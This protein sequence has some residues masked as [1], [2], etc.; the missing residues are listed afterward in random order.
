MVPRSLPCSQSIGE[1]Y[2]HNSRWLHPQVSN[3]SPKS[4]KYCNW[5]L[6]TISVFGSWYFLKYFLISALDLHLNWSVLWHLVVQKQVHLQQWRPCK[7]VRVNSQLPIK[8]SIVGYEHHLPALPLS[9]WLKNLLTYLPLNYIKEKLITKL[10]RRNLVYIKVSSKKFSEIQ[11]I[12]HSFS[13]RCFCSLLKPTGL[14][15]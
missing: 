7:I 5:I 11:W 15:T 2:W 3:P 6:L 8:I 13:S 1:Q 12:L 10:E 14:A 4:K 9:N